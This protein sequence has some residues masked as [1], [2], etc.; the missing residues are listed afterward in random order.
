MGSESP[1]QRS[2][3]LLRQRG[4]TARIVEYFLAPANKR[5]DL[6]GFGDIL[7]CKVGETGSLIVQTT[8]A[9]HISDRIK[10][11][12]ALDAYRVWLM[13]GNKVEFHGWK[14]DLKT[15]R[16]VCRIE[17]GDLSPLDMV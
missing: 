12:E 2:M 11:A 13:C 5:I 15:N 6:F 1:T 4:Y 10:K 16:W 14:K 3:K 17:H 7:A 9:S 8:T